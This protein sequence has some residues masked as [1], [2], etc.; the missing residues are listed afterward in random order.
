MGRR[1]KISADEVK[2]MCPVNRPISVAKLARE[3][4]VSEPTVRSRLRGLRR[5]GE[6]ILPTLKGVMLV[7]IN[8]GM[9]EKIAE[10]IHA[11]AEWLQR[12]LIGMTL[13][14]TVTKKPFR[15]ASRILL[16]HFSKVERQAL[17]STMLLLGRQID[18]LEVDEDIGL[19]ED[20][21]HK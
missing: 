6:H 14:A 17:K 18:A 4:K 10:T 7:D 21:S 13:I 3:L 20:K 2:D 9:T 1:N 11:T 12:S 15:E 16:P 8:G 5:T 19:L